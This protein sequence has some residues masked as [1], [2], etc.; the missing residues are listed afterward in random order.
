LGSNKKHEVIICPK[1]ETHD[2]HHAYGFCPHCGTKLSSKKVASDKLELRDFIGDKYKWQDKMII[3]PVTISYKNLETDH[4]ILY[5]NHRDSG[6][7]YDIDTDSYDVFEWDPSDNTL[8][9]ESFAK[10]IEKYEEYI[11]WLESQGFVV[12]YKFGILNYIW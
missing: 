6:S 3:M 11:Q 12:E 5:P 8:V 1:D 4:I 2:I 9:E 7:L 10:F